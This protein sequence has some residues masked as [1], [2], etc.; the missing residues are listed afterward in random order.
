MA[1]CHNRA[2]LRILDGCL[3]NGGLYVKLGQGL[4]SMNHVLPKEYT[5]T[6]EILQDQVLH[7]GKDEVRLEIL[8]KCSW[9]DER[10]FLFTV[11]T[12]CTCQNIWIV[13]MIKYR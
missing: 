3:K 8:V 2:A 7:R 4:V 6:L 12:R 11:R 13:I 1:P 9:L 5:S 10:K